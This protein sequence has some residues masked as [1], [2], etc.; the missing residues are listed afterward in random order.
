MRFAY[1]LMSTSVQIWKPK[2]EL[3]CQNVWPVRKSRVYFLLWVIVSHFYV[4]FNCHNT[5]HIDNM[6]ATQPLVKGEFKIYCH[7]N[8]V[9]SHDWQQ[10]TGVLEKG[11]TDL[12]WSKLHR[13]PVLTKERKNLRK[14]QIDRIKINVWM[15]E[16]SRQHSKVPSSCVPLSASKSTLLLRAKSLRTREENTQHKRWQC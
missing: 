14:L 13:K 16:V 2:T 9:N 12:E 4:L 10:L 1:K 8:K 15:Y 5:P 3:P 6:L 7:M 11:C